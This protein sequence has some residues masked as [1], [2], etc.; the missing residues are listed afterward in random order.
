VPSLLLQPL[1]ENAIRHG[2]ASRLG[3]ATI[4]VRARVDGAQLLLD[5]ED[6]GPGVPDDRD[7]L[8]SGLGLSLTADRLRLLYGEAHSMSA[9]NVPGEGFAVRL[10]IP[11]R[12]VAQRDE[13]PG[14]RGI[15]AYSAGR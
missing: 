6:D 7:V 11:R 12:T 9:G 8:R 1:V 14:E 4:V 10:R 13:A 15:S 5:V 2:N 3:I